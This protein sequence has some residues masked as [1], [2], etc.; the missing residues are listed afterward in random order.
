MDHGDVDRALQM[1]IGWRRHG[2][3]IRKDYDFST[4]LDGIAFV[5]R[6]AEAAEAANHHPD[7]RVGYRRVTIELSSHDAGGVTNCPGA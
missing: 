3:L 5:N 4:Y 2:A 6:V 7:M 1:L